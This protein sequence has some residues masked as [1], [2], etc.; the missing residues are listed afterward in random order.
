MINLYSSA[1]SNCPRN[2]SAIVPRSMILARES[3]VLAA[4]SFQTSSSLQPLQE[5]LAVPANTCVFAH[6]NARGQ[7]HAP[8]IML[9]WENASLSSSGGSPTTLDHRFRRR[10]S[11]HRK[12][13]RYTASTLSLASCTPRTRSRNRR[14]PRDFARSSEEGVARHV[15]RKL[16]ICLLARVSRSMGI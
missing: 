3:F 1:A 2:R 16:R 12:T 14:L 6:V 8:R 9:S 11:I 5:D 4:I 15:P 10:E 13:E 7:S